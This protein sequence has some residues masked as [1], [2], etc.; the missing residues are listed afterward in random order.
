MTKLTHDKRREVIYSHGK[1]RRR[2]Y[3]IE[4]NFRGVLIFM[5]SLQVATFSTPRSFSPPYGKLTSRAPRVRNER[6]RTECAAVAM[7]TSTR[8]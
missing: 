8:T 3:H 2:S 7:E 5:V 4:G 6:L 1:N